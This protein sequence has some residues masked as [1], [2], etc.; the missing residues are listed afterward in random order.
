MYDGGCG[1]DKCRGDSIEF[2]TQVYKRSSK[3]KVKNFWFLR[4]SWDSQPCGQAAI[5][6][7]WILFNATSSDRSIIWLFFN[8][9]C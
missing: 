7:Q 6:L 9:L 8:K 3:T 2:P 5:F 4:Q 1:E